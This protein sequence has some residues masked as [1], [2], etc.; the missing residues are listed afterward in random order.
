MALELQELAPLFR[1]RKG[2]DRPPFCL[3]N[4]VVFSNFQRPASG[5]W[6]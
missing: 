3:N 5:H 2:S 1:I 6:N 4:A